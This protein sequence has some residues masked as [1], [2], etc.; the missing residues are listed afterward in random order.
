VVCGE[1]RV[2]R[3]ARGYAPASLPLPPGFEKSPD[4]LALG[5]ELKNTFCMVKDGRAIL[6][7]HMGDLENISTY[8]DYKKNLKLYQL[9]FDHQPTALVIDAHPEYLSNKLGHQQAEAGE[10]PLWKVQHHHAHIAACLAENAWPLSAGKVLGIALDGL[11]FGDDGSLWGGEF[12]LADYYGSQRLASFKAVAL[13]GGSQAMREPWR[14]TYSHLLA[15]MDWQEL[16]AGYDDL[17]LLSF[18]K[19]KP[20]ATLNT[21]LNKQ[22][23]SPLAS[24][25]GRLFDAVAAAIGVCRDKVFYEGQAAIELEALVSNKL[26][27]EQ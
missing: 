23:N 26:L 4:V 7:Q 25:V 16:V 14:N 18:L 10:L 12:L 2:L 22:L 13:V 20:I 3:R 1:P 27:Q 6:S 8:I 9:L 17:E 24:S 21:M 11:G 5:G 15:V 19:K